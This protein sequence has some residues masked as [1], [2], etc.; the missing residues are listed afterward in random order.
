MLAT[1]A[2]ATRSSVSARSSTACSDAH[3][4]AYDGAWPRDSA[5]YSILASEWPAVRSAAC[6]SAGHPR[7]RRGSA[8]GSN[9]CSCWASTQGCRRC[10]YAAV[11]ATSADSRCAPRS[12]CSPREPT[13]P[14]PQ[15]LAELRGELAPPD[16]GGAARRR[17]R[18]A[19]L[20]PS[21][22][23]HRDVGRPGERARPRRG[24]IG[25]L[26]GRAVHAEP[27]EG[28]GRRLRRGD[29]GPGAAPGAGRLNLAAPPSPPD[30][31]DAAALALC[32]LAW[33]PWR[34]RLERA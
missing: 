6:R 15:R 24:G 7:C 22:R 21:E 32:H 13:D 23:A 34:A 16:R 26:R 1:S 17:G 8:L 33:A 30:A 9:L 14:L 12:A 18:R 31:A 2:R 19:R 11:D 29:Q 25:R 20:L 28:G 3:M 4:P 27:G 10:G 5:F